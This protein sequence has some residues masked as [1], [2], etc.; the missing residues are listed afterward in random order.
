MRS[1]IKLCGV[2]DATSTRMFKTIDLITSPGN[3]NSWP[4]C[5]KLT[6][7]RPSFVFTRAVGICSCEQ[8]RVEPGLVLTRVEP[9]LV[10]AV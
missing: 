7:V 4:A 6:R 5:E 2:F 3:A 9:G 10:C 8:S 1:P